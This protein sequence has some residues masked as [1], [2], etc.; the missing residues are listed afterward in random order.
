MRLSA[1]HL[2]ICTLLLAAPGLFAE[3]AAI[4]TPAIPQVSAPLGAPIALFNGKDVDDWIWVT[5]PT[6]GT[7][8]KLPKEAIWVVKDGVLRSNGKEVAGFTPGYLREQQ[9][10]TNYVLTVEQ[11]HVTKGG[12]GI[13]VA[14]QGEDKVWPKNLQIQG[15]FG[16]VGDFVDQ[17]G[18]KMT[19]DAARTKVGKDVVTTKMAPSSEKELGGWN[20]VVTTVD[21]GRVWVTVNGVLQNMATDT[22]PLTGTIGLQAE[23]AIMEFRKIEVQPIE[24]K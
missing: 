3:E 1:R 23:G 6:K 12:G 10:F 20:T 21:H 7:T 16:S 11:R 13:L 17:Y 8:T 24:G 15:T 14:L 9:K 4:T 5:D 22:E 18:I 2:A 19:P